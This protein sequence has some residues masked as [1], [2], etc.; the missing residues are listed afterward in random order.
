M[1]WSQTPRDFPESFFVLQPRKCFIPYGAANEQNGRFQ[2]INEQSEQSE[3]N[4]RNERTNETNEIGIRRRSSMRR[5]M[6]FD[7]LPRCRFF[8]VFTINE[9]RYYV[10]HTSKALKFKFHFLVIDSILSQRER[11]GSIDEN[12]DG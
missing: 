5:R 12:S 7:I 4:E 3:Q 11:N 8:T 2:R 10:L 9:S 6:N 1:S